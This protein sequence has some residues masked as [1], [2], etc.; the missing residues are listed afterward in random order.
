LVILWTYWKLG[1]AQESKLNKGE[2]ID[3]TFFGEHSL[4]GIVEAV[5]KVTTTIVFGRAM[6]GWAVTVPRD[7]VRR[8][9]DRWLLDLA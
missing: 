9:E 1:K 6:G 7:W 4:P 2:P 3:V 8:H 5:D